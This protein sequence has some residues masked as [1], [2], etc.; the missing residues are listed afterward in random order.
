MTGDVLSSGTQVLTMV[1]LATVVS[2]AAMCAAIA[3][4]FGWHPLKGLM[5][6]LIPVPLFTWAVTWYV[7]SRVGGSR[8]DEVDLEPVSY[9]LPSDFFD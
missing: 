8:A 9:T 3:A 7:A 5:I 2:G 6:G 4:R 1:L